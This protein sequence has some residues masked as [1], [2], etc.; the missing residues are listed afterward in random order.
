[1]HPPEPTS[2]DAAFGRAERYC[3]SL[4]TTRRGQRRNFLMSSLANI[5][6]AAAV[7]GVVAVPAAAQ[8]NPYP[9]QPGYDYPAYPGQP[10]PQQYP[11]QYPQTYPGYGQQPYGQNAIGQIID[12]LLGNRYNVTDR[13]AVGLCAS[14]AMA[15]AQNQYRGY[16][17]NYGYRPGIAAPMMRVTA[18]TD[19]QRRSGGLRVKGL[20]DTG[21]GGQ[22]GYQDRRYA[23][24]DLTFRCNVDYRGYVTNVRLAR[25]SQYRR[26]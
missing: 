4:R 26:Y 23:R 20:I 17:Q 18:I 25:N 3:C 24:G 19:V 8:Y 13:R 9:N 7:A 22:Y 11:Q 12:Q 15:Q 16:G 2:A 6:T 1:M 10:Y 14:A 5:F 21:Y